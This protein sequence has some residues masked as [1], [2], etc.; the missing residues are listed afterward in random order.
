MDR[1]PKQIFPA[2]IAGGWRRGDSQPLL[3][4]AHRSPPSGAPAAGGAPGGMPQCRRARH[5][6]GP[7]LAP[8]F[9]VHPPY[10]NVGSIMRLDPSLADLIDVDTPVQKVG[11]GFVWIEG[12]VGSAARTVSAVL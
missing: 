1:I 4:Q 9:T 11:D 5:S 3:A 2:H 10:A 8:P 6:A 12:P 7:Q